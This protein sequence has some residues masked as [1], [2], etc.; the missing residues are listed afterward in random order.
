M[1]QNREIGLQR[2]TAS[3]KARGAGRQYWNKLLTATRSGEQGYG[4]PATTI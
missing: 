2:A 3:I 1:K 4:Q